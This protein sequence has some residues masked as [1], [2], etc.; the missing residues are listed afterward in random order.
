MFAENV[1]PDSERAWDR[2]MRTIEAEPDDPAMEVMT[3]METTTSHARRSLV[4]AVAAVVVVAFILGSLNGRGEITDL[5]SASGDPNPATEVRYIASMVDAF[6]DADMNRWRAHFAPGADVFGANIDLESNDDYYA[7]FM[8]LQHRLEITGSCRSLV[9]LTARHRVRCPM[10]QSDRFHR[11]GG[12]QISDTVT[13]SFEDG[14]ISRMSFDVVSTT[15][16]PTYFTVYMKMDVDFRLWLESAYPEV[17]AV[18]SDTE[19]SLVE[20]GELFVRYV[21]DFVAQSDD[22]PARDPA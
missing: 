6:N 9:D 16:S 5:G 13:F 21:D 18:L 1:V 3:N 11:T 8:A 15:R 7:G 14:R 22:Y 20:S 2:M 12:L 19:T 4:L 10:S 17:A